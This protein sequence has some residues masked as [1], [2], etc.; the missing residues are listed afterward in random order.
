MRNLF[1]FIW[2]NNFFFL[3]IL[4]E[5]AAFYLIIRHN[6]FQN[7]G[8]FNSSNALTGTIYRSYDNITDYLN[9]KKA[10]ELLAEENA[11]LLS[12]SAGAFVDT[13][14][15]I[16]VIEDNFKRKFEYREAKVINNTINRRNNF[17]TLDR[18]SAHGIETGM[19]VIAPDGVVGIV[20]QV[21]ENFCTVISLLHKNTRISSKLKSSG[22]LGPVSWEGGDPSEGSLDDI[23]KHAKLA[24]GDTIV[25]SGASG[26][27][28]EGIMVGTIA[29][30]TLKD[31]D[32][33]YRIKL[34][35]A[36]D[37]GKLSYVY[38]VNN[39][40]AKELKELELS[41]ENDN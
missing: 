20:N 32:N 4:L 24:I 9:L 37:F 31:G 36:T 28:P 2:K 14:T 38:V 29:D 27:F 6:K 22:Y 40:M 1:L 35:L 34:N 10:N 23:P 12:E 11:R 7:T 33:F 41:I 18:G 39:L 26:T 30:F 15:Q 17:I 19:G 21:S 13:N 8:F 16:A 5:V 3:F 25:T